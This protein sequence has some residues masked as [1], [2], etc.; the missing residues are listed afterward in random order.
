MP[1]FVPIGQSKD[2]LVTPYFSSKTKTFEYRYR[3]KFQSGDLAVIG[4]FSNDD[5]ERNKLRYFSQLVGN[6][7]LAYGIVLNL[8]L[9]VSVTHHILVIMFILIK[10]LT[11]KFQLEKQLLKPINFLTAI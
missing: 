2:I 11:Q 5:L 10:D 4:A 7:K 8:M 1:Y 3:Q 9:E 6:F